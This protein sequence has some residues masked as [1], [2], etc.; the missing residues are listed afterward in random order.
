MRLWLCALLLLSASLWNGTALGHAYLVQSAPADGDLLRQPPQALELAFN[1]A[2]RFASATHVDPKGATRPLTSADKNS[3]KLSI[4]LPAELAQGS[5]LI[6]WR[7]ISGDGHAVGGSIVFSI[8]KA[9]GGAGAGDNLD[10]NLS[11][12]SALVVAARYLLL[13]GCAFGTGAAFFHVWFTQGA[14]HRMAPWIATW[15]LALGAA[16]TIASIILSGLELH[17]Q[18]LNAIGDL[19]FWRAGLRQPIGIGALVALGAL[20]AAAI[21]LWTKGAIARAFSLFALSGAIFFLVLAGHARGW[22]P[23]W[24]SAAAITLHV[25]AMIVWTGA[26][27]PLALG[28]VRA[29][30]KFL[31]AL[32]RFS[33]IAPMLYACLLGSGAALAATQAF[34]SRPAGATAWDLALAIKLALVVAVTGLAA[35]SRYRFTSPA[36]TGDPLA[37]RVLKRTICA[38]IVLAVLILA[39]ASVWRVTP[40]PASLALVAEPRFQIHVHGIDAMASLVIAPARVG[41]VH[42]RLEPKTADMSPL[43]VKDVSLA[44]IAEGEGVQPVRFQLRQASPYVWEANGVILPSPGIWKLHVDLLIDDFRRVRLDALLSLKR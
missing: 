35:F 38:E 11:A 5:H 33:N 4:Q 25:A 20:T 2:V 8:G 29:D 24:L 13:L 32:K 26:L 31:L 30:I 16:A 21:A 7:V 3:D 28:A 36:L 10:L 44:L 6:S 18:G 12:L 1:E 17:G 9:S 40:P 43:D 37:I 23:Q 22:A 42:V 27:A 41:P 39:V 19:A 15:A 14:N 34:G